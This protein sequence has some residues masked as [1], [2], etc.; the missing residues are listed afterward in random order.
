MV[1]YLNDT[2]SLIL[3][4]LSNYLH[5]SSGFQRKSFGA[6]GIRKI[7]AHLPGEGRRVRQPKS[8]ES[9]LFTTFFSF[10]SLEFRFLK[11]P[12]TPCP[13]YS[14]KA[15]RVLSRFENID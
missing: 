7:M 13:T 8:L 14:A 2:S 1:K 6:E 4:F 3:K 15:V 12:M 11:K 5:S 9:A 10:E